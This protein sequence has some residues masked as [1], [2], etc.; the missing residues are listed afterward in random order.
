MEYALDPGALALLG[1]LERAGYRAYL[2]GGCVRDLLRGERPHD[3]D[4]CTSARP[5]EVLALFSGETVVPTGLRHGTVT[6]RLEQR[7][8]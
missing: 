3:W 4:I 7:P 6:V 8:Y 1:D 5:E 2:V